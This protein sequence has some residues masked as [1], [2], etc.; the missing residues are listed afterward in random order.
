MEGRAHTVPYRRDDTPVA[1][2]AAALPAAARPRT[3]AA[4]PFSDPP[5]IA[6]A[7]TGWD[8]IAARIPQAWQRGVEAQT[9]ARLLAEVDL[10]PGD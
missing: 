9:A 5:A 4:C 7:L 8:P 2:W 10:G 3:V 6:A 1:S